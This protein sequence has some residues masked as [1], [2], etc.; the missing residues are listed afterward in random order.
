MASIWSHS[1]KICLFE[2][3]KKFI[4]SFMDALSVEAWMHFAF[5]FHVTRYMLHAKCVHE[6]VH[7]TQAYPYLFYH[8]E[9]GYQLT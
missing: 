1:V 3:E 4:D 8:W 7:V 5:V 2:R 6:G 9:L